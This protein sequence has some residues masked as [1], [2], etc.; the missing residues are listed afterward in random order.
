MKTEEILEKMEKEKGYFNYNNYHIV[1]ATEKM[2]ELR[3]DLTENS[4][5]PYNMAHGGLIFGLG[6]TAMG[7]AVGEKTLTITANISYIKSGTG[8]Y[9]MARAEQVKKGNSICFAKAM[10]YNDNEEL[11]A[12]MNA[13]YY[14]IK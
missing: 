8:K 5:N 12:T 10:I 6:D 9:I 11:I 7:M 4:M 1:K 14:L 13:S 3:A 2:I